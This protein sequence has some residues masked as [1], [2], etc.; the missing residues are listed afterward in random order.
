MQSFYVYIAADTQ[1]PTL[2]TYIQFYNSP[3]TVQVCFAEVES[4]HIIFAPEFE[5]LRPRQ[6]PSS[7][8]PAFGIGFGDGKMHFTEDFFGCLHC[9]QLTCICYTDSLDRFELLLL[10]TACKKAKSRTGSKQ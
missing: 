4:P 3:N 5:K 6:R 8:Q 9:L 2:L 10:S 1:L 7:Y